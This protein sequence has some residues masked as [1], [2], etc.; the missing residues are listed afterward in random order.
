MDECSHRV[1]R[2][3]LLRLLSLIGDVGARA[4]DDDVAAWLST[5]EFYAWNC[6]EQHRDAEPAQCRRILESC[7]RILER[8]EDLAGASAE[9][10]RRAA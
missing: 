7:H 9:D 1:L 8:V 3:A 6:L 4:H 2:L 5:V 10:N